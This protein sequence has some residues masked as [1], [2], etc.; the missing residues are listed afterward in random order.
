MGY[1]YADEE[2]QYTYPDRYDLLLEKALQRLVLE[3]QKL[4]NEQKDKTTKNQEDKK[5][6]AKVE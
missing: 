1:L 5:E 3:E 2:I 4:M 6:E